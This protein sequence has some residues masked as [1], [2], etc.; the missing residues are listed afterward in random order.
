MNVLCVWEGN[1]CSVPTDDAESGWYPE[2][3]DA[4]ILKQNCN[5]NE[6]YGLL[7]DKLENF[8]FQLVEMSHDGFQ[9]MYNAY[10]SAAMEIMIAL[11]TELKA[12]YVSK[13]FEFIKCVKGCYRVED[14]WNIK[15]TDKNGNDFGIFIYDLFIDDNISEDELK[16]LAFLKYVEDCDFK[17]LRRW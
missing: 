5:I 12:Y 6:D 16:H 15:G 7:Y 2:Y 9:P 1:L 13:E 14:G 8:E 11:L 10:D 3:E 17:K 4:K